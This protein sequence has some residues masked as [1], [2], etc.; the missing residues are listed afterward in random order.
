MNGT[1]GTSSQCVFF[2]IGSVVPWLRDEDNGDDKINMMYRL[3]QTH[4]QASTADVRTHSDSM[5]FRFESDSIKGY[6]F[7]T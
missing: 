4:T 3:K 5:R 7:S 1:Y 6:V 2:D